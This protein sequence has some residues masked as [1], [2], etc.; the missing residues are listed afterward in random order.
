[1]LPVS[2][3]GRKTQMSVP[4]SQSG[5]V[6]FCLILGLINIPAVAFG[7][8][9][10][11]L[12]MKKFRINVL[13]AAK[14]SLGSS[15]FGYLLLLS[16]FAMGCE[17][18]DVAGLTVSYH[19]T[20]QITHYEQ[21]LFAECN[22]GCICS[23]NDWDPICG[24][25]GITYIS[26]CLAGCQASNGSGKSTVFYNCSCVGILESSS[27]SSSAVVGPCQKGK[28]CPK[29]F[30][31]FLVVSVITSYTLSVGGTPGYILLL[32][33]IKPHLKSFA[34]GIYTLAV[35]VL[36][37][38]P[39]PVYY[40]VA[41]DTTCLKWGSKRCGGR[42]AC[43][44]YDSRALRYVYLGL[45]LVL[46]TMSIFFSI[47]VLW[48]LR[49]RSTPQDETISASRRGTGLTKKR[50]DNFVNSDHLIQTTYWPEKETRL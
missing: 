11:G 2:Q 34:L 13:G 9:S 47:A 25:N 16:L 15:F 1:M 35:R 24:E 31:Y 39:A 37:G 33:C 32:R 46:G 40:G 42:G 7:I 49:K 19:G 22:S 4:K 12:I 27:R 26:A 18:S 3:Y 44:L 10:G 45:T 23:K 20:K 5:R 38:I 30:L 36:A 6:F 17:N 28:E 8:F 41:I 21:G 14:L 50:K 29:M 48:I 43:R